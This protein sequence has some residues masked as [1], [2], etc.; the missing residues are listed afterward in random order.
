VFDL[1]WTNACIFQ[2]QGTYIHTY[3]NPV[4]E[5]YVNFTRYGI[6][7]QESCLM[8]KELYRLGHLSMKEIIDLSGRCKAD[9]AH[10]FCMPVRTIEN[11]YYGKRECAPY[12]RL[13]LLRQ[14]HLI[15]LGKYI[16][17]ESAK[18]FLETV[19]GIYDKH[20]APVE[21]DGPVVTDPYV[22]EHW[23]VDGILGDKNFLDPEQVDKTYRDLAALL[24]E[25][26]YLSRK[27]RD[28]GN[29]WI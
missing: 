24:E 25:T 19:P 21:A 13:L 20:E 16:T 14:Y 23:T 1:L 17:T 7:Y 27:K 18:R 3:T 10:E 4:S 11:W 8:L 5:E 26:E 9:L 22:D 28:Q 2:D 15:R 6:S 29:G 12:F